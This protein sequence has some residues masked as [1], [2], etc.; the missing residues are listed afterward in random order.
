MSFLQIFLLVV[1]FIYLIFQLTAFRD[2]PSWKIDGIEAEGPRVKLL[3]QSLKLAITILVIVSIIS[4]NGHLRHPW[5]E[6]VFPKMLKLSPIAISLGLSINALVICWLFPLHS[7]AFILT[8]LLLTLFEFWCY[9][10]LKTFWWMKK[11]KKI[12]SLMKPNVVISD[13]LLKMYS[14]D[15]LWIDR[16]SPLGWTSFCTTYHCINRGSSKSLPD[17][18]A[19]KIIDLKCYLKT[20][21]PIQIPDT[22]I[23]SDTT[24]NRIEEHLTLPTDIKFDLGYRLIHENIAHVLHSECMMNVKTIETV[25]WFTEEAEYNLNSY[26]ELKEPDG[27]ERSRI[28]NW[29]RQLVNAVHFLHNQIDERTGLSRAHKNIKPENVLFYP[30][31]DHSSNFKVKLSDCAVDA[32][33]SRYGEICTLNNQF[34]ISAPEYVSGSRLALHKKMELSGT[35]DEINSMNLGA[36][37]FGLGTILVFMVKGPIYNFIHRCKPVKIS[38]D[39]DCK[40]TRVDLTW[41]NS[42]FTI[43]KVFATEMDQELIKLLRR[44]LEKNPNCRSDTSV[45]LSSKWLQ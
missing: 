24:Q 34:S 35:T 21:F 6:R 28:K 30:T 42:K 16:D 8:V 18:V 13:Q 5:R 19:I 15:K 20:K 25:I 22:Q 38:S 37:I 29:F 9:E 41:K 31:Q 3:N 23:P 32:Y 14:A 36:D 12:D 39:L 43:K 7:V 33:F 45:I 2:I 44:M 17:K 26:L 1:S 11:D 27:I 4:Y 10:G 40:N